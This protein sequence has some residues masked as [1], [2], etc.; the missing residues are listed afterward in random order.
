MLEKPD[1]EEQQLINCLRAE[2][3]FKIAGIDFLPLGADQNTA[4]YRALT[5]DGSPYFVKLRRGDFNQAIVSVPRFLYDQGSEHILPSLFT[6]TDKLWAELGPFKVIVYPYIE[7]QNGF[8]AK[9]A[10]QKWVVFGRALKGI[11]SARVP[12]GI[13]HGLPRE[14]FSPRWRKIVRFSLARLIDKSYE[15]PVAVEMAAYLR[16]KRHETIDLLGEASG[17]REFCFAKLHDLSS[18]TRISIYGI[19]Y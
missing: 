8:E 18:V 3:G 11:H 4:V 15:D 1:L 14:D 13:T 19:C 2:F 7:G 10:D 12:P 5:H 16:K 6:K 9:M 17:L